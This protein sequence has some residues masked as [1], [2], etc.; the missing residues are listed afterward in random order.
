MSL[1]VNKVAEALTSEVEYVE[2]LDDSYLKPLY[3]DGFEFIID[4]KKWT[5]KSAWDDMVNNPAWL[6]YKDSKGFIKV[7][8]LDKIPMYKLNKMWIEKAKSEGATIIDIGYPIG[9]DMSIS[10]FYEMEKSIINWD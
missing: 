9:H 3:D 7:E 8:Y 4:G 2:I 6:T 1:H 5:V 10:G